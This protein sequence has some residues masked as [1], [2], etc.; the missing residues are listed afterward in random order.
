MLSSI[1]FYCYQVSADFSEDKASR[2][3]STCALQIFNISITESAIG[4]NSRVKKLYTVGG[5]E[6]PSD[7]VIV[8]P[9]RPQRWTTMTQNKQIEEVVNNTN[10]GNCT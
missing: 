4:A 9:A 3:G 10:E 1:Q 7:L 8:L 6:A 2:F 5:L